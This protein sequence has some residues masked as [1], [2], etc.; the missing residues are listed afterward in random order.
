MYCTVFRAPSSRLGSENSNASVLAMEAHGFGS[1]FA[2][3]TTFASSATRE[4][5][6][7]CS[8][9][10]CICSESDSDGGVGEASLRRR[11]ARARRRQQ[12][13]RTPPASCF[14]CLCCGGGICRPVLAALAAALV[15]GALYW[16]DA[17]SPRPVDSED[18]VVQMLALANKGMLR[19][20]PIQCLTVRPFN[21][22]LV[23]PT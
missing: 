17:F 7:C 1:G 18:S 20:S 13:A 3:S 15:F 21:T 14:T 9:C 2:A 10:A 12:R 5:S 23:A 8:S 4:R 16:F 6:S 11:R 22:L 19:W